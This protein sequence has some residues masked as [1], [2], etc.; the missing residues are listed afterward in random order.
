MRKSD[1]LL[2]VFFTKQLFSNLIVSSSETAFFFAGMYIIKTIQFLIICFF[3]MTRMKEDP[4]K[5][6]EIDPVEDDPLALDR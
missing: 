3:S 2:H 4:R 1:L 5:H 6:L